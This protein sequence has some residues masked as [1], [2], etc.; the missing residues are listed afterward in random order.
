LT[1]CALDRMQSFW[2]FNV[3]HSSSP[4]DIDQRSVLDHDVRIAPVA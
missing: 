4:N 3:A 2:T 1:V